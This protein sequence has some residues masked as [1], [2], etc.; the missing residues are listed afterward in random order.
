MLGPAF[1]FITGIN[2]EQSLQSIA[3]LFPQ[4]APS[5]AYIMYGDERGKLGPFSCCL[6][7]S[8]TVSPLDLLLNK[9]KAEMLNS[10]C[11][12]TAFSKNEMP[13]VLQKFSVSH[14]QCSVGHFDIVKALE[15]L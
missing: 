7:F 2:G 15:Y 12:E 6:F 14:F 1:H 8:T 11:Q 13:I 5:Q 9:M 10:C 3:C 4:G